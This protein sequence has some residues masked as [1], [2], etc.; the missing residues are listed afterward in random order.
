MGLEMIFF[1]FTISI[2]FTGRIIEYLIIFR[3]TFSLGFRLN[4]EYASRT[5]LHLYRPKVYDHKSRPSTS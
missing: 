3:T 2:L 4:F 1:F 5:K